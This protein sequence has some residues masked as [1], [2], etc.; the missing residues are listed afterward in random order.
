M[1]NIRFFLAP[2]SIV[3]AALMALTGCETTNEGETTGS[4][5][6][7]SNGSG[8]NPQTS[9][10]GAS[11]GSTT[12]SGGGDSG[13]GGGGG[14]IDPGPADVTAEL[15]YINQRV[16]REDDAFAQGGTARLELYDPQPLPVDDR[17]E[18]FNADGERCTFESG[19]EWPELLSD[20][21][22][23]PM[24]PF[25]DAGNLSLT[26]TGAPGPV[27][28]EY[29]DSYY[30]R[31]SPE[32]VQQG[33]FT[34]N[35]FYPPEYIP[36][37]AVATIDAAGGND[38]GS[39]SVPGVELAADYTV[40]S[41]NLVAGGDVIDT[42]AALDFAWS[43]PVPGDRMA[44]IVKDAFSFV[45]CVF[46]DDGQAQ[47]PAEAMA[48]LNGGQFTTFT[49][50][51][52]REHSETHRVESADGQQIDVALTSRHVQIGRFDSQ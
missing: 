19:T 48:V 9:G 36:H 41:P 22:T 42:G 6:S 17:T 50:Q 2:S 29:Y 28:Y 1:R 13:V 11:T 40:S 39:F 34:H 23:W 38:V 18:F 51:T 49:I 14:V 20:G 10:A 35:S 33:S 27:V 24:G 46:D 47:V 45:K 8:G 5:G 3:L 25:K 16:F 43:P 44:V 7:S 26:P 31:L 52:W 4:S 21:S 32:A 37:G 15:L 30:L 12:T